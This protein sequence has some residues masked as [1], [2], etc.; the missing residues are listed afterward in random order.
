MCEAR[1]IARIHLVCPIRMHIIVYLNFFIG[2]DSRNKE[3]E[4]METMLRSNHVCYCTKLSR[5]QFMFSK[6]KF[7]AACL[8]RVQETEHEVESSKLSWSCF[9]ARSRQ[10]KEKQQEGKKK[11]G[12]REKLLFPSS[13]HSIVLSRSVCVPALPSMSFFLTVRIIL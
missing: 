7:M 11:K 5:I 3:I 13:V 1:L 12:R 9:C 4:Q 6:H 10:K 8:I 2:Q